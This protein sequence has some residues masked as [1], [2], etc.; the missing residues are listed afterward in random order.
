[1][2]EADWPAETLA[3]MTRG[4]APEPQ[5]V[6]AWGAGHWWAAICQQSSV[7]IRHGDAE[8]G[9]WTAAVQPAFCAV[10]SPTVHL[11]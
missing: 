5:V 2:D 6:I 10:E 1:V 7:I 8:T 11:A 9:P 3:R 4:G